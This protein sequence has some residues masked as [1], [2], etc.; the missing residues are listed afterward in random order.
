[1]F[2]CNGTICS[3]FKEQISSASIMNWTHAFFWSE[4]HFLECVTQYSYDH[5]YTTKFVLVVA[6]IVSAI[7]I[8]QVL[9]GT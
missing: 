4:V 8:P 5:Y 9:F 2:L 3:Y 7:A 6:T 1:M